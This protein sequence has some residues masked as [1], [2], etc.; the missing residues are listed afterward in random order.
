MHCINDFPRWQSCDAM[1]SD[2]ET[3]RLL[4]RQF[5]LLI[6]D[7][8]Y[9]ECALALVHRFRVPFMY[10][11]TVGFYTGSLQMAGNPA[12]YSMSPAFYSSFTDDMTMMQR[13]VNTVFHVFANVV[14]AVSG[15]CVCVLCL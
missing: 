7:G 13:M 2:H 11:N 1:L 5:D 14:H 4:D 10:I 8:A 9:P 12:V 3:R 6:L 15:L